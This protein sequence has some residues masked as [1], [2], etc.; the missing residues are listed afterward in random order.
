MPV[1]TILLVADPQVLRLETRPR[2]APTPR[3]ADTA[4]DAARRG[5]GNGGRCRG[6][7]DIY[8]GVP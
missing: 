6:E 4:E 8:A 1:I 7:Q 2:G 3:G 5:P